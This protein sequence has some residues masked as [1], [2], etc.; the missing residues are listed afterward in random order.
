LFRLFYRSGKNGSQALAE[1]EA[2]SAYTTPEAREFIE[3]VKQSPNGLCPG[4][5]R[6]TCG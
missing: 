6:Y 2:D 3:F 1:A 5:S 4:P